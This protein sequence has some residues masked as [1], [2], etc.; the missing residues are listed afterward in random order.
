MKSLL[1][2]KRGLSTVVTTLIIL[3]VSVLL[4][5]VVTF[6][7]INVTTT[8]VQEESIHLTKLH[9]WHNGTT[10]SEVAIL[11]INSGGRDFVLD[12]IAVR[13]QQS[14]WDNVYYNKTQDAISPDLTYITPN[15]NST[16]LGK[17]I[18][19]GSNTYGLTRGTAG[20]DMIL[21]SGWSMI[22]YITDPDSLSVND[23]GVTLGITIF[24]ANAQYY[25]EANVEASA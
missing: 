11:I 24:T 9:F 22:C 14:A 2:S 16:L 25:K 7:A 12:K 5:T 3:V 19:L 4:A 21:K 23:I 1:K 6:Y 8:R 13:G 15:A 18:T 10:Y 20:N 17:T